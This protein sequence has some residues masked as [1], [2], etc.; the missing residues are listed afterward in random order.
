MP[1]TSNTS[2]PY[3]TNPNQQPGGTPPAAAPAPQQGFGQ[4]LNNASAAITSGFQTALNPINAITGGIQNTVNTI[5]GAW[6]LGNE[7]VGGIKSI[8]G[9]D[10]ADKQAAAQQEQANQ[11]RIVDER[12][13][14]RGEEVSD[15]E[16]RAR[17]QQY[18][19]TN[20]YGSVHW[21]YGPDGT[22]HQVSTLDE[23]QQAMKDAAGNLI[24]QVGSQDSVNQAVNDITQSQMDMYHRQNDERNQEQIRTT[25][26]ALLRKGISED[27]PAFRAAMKNVYDAQAQAEQNASDQA[28]AQGY[29][30]GNQTYQN[31]LAGFNTL[32]GFKDPL[33]QYKEMAGAGAYGQSAVQPAWNYSAGREDARTQAAYQQ[34]QLAE[35]QRQFNKTQAQEM[36]R[37]AIEQG[38]KHNE[39]E[40]QQKW[41]REMKELDYGHSDQRDIDQYNMDLDKLATQNAWKNESDEE[42]Y[43]QNLKRDQAARDDQ[44]WENQLAHERTL[45]TEEMRNAFTEESDFRKNKIESR[46]QRALE[47]ERGV[48]QQQLAKQKHDAAMAELKKKNEDDLLKQYWHDDMELKKAMTESN[49]KRLTEKERLELD[50]KIEDLKEAHYNSWTEV[51]NRGLDTVAKAGNTVEGVVNNAVNV[52]SK[53]GE[54]S[55]DAAV[56]GAKAIKRAFS[57]ETSKRIDEDRAREQQRKEFDNNYSMQIK[58]LE[59]MKA[60]QELRQAQEK[61]AKEMADNKSGETANRYAAQSTILKSA[62]ESKILPRPEDYGEGK[63]LHGQMM[64]YDSEASPGKRYS[65]GPAMPGFTGKGFWSMKA[66]GIKPEGHKLV[67]KDAPG[68]VPGPVIRPDSAKLPIN[69]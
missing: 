20:A 47:K 66:G 2:L 23:H 55:I 32:N 59:I 42:M 17:A 41:D 40:A 39:T 14:M 62:N 4:A 49:N 44:S 33:E 37:L 57:G 30:Y 67:K 58:N 53:F 22:P 56:G 27:S 25:R 61:H 48:I 11:Q 46:N 18:S 16:R 69:K 15:Q 51:A 3:R 45:D 29:Q 24:G 60:N 63:P 28:V 19:Q 38:F 5:R 13:Q 36:N 7:M 9:W 34:Q 26:E 31:Y 54:K 21:E 12:N 65:L 10:S 68:F 50:N 64:I 43:S 35:N 52:A 6:D 1:I 8:F